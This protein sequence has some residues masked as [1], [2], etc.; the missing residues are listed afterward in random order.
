MS[1]PK[2]HSKITFNVKWKWS[3][4]LKKGK[5]KWGIGK[6]Y[7]RREMLIIIIEIKSFRPN[8]VETQYEIFRSFRFCLCHLNQLIAQNFHLPTLFWENSNHQNRSSPCWILLF[9]ARFSLTK[10]QE[11]DHFR[12]RHSSLI[13]V[14][15]FWRTNMPFG[16]PWGLKI[17]TQKY[18]LLMKNHTVLILIQCLCPNVIQNK[19]I[20]IVFLPLSR[21]CF[22]SFQAHM[23]HVQCSQYLYE[24]LP[25]CI[26]CMLNGL[27]HFQHF[28]MKV[29]RGTIS[30]K[31]THIYLHVCHGIVSIPYHPPADH[32]THRILPLDAI[33]LSVPS[34][35]SATQPKPPPPT[36]PP[37][38]YHCNCFNSHSN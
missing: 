2:I 22:Y 19:N 36:T 16:Y 37:S 38:Q 17:V 29:E 1:V 9:F 35:T 8:V 30:L 6:L 3:N 21:F 4:H 15:I 11:I 5:W 7:G 18:S 32:Y 13:F 14:L 33:T 20:V 27:F 25:S 28:V 12:G 10:T 26:C 34:D 31:S 24:V 23:H